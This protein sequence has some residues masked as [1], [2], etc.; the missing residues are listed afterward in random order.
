MTGGVGNRRVH[1]RCTV[2]GSPAVLKLFPRETGEV[3]RSRDG[4]ELHAR[5][6]VALG[7]DF[8]RDERDKE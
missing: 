1:R 4:G 5:V 6:C 2:V 7:P 3:R 8:R